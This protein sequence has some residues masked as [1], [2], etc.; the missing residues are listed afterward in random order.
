MARSGAR[1]RW[2]DIYQRLSGKS[3][4]FWR[5]AWKGQEGWRLANT[6]LARMLG[7]PVDTTINWK[8]RGISLTA[9]NLQKVEVVLAKLKL[10]KMRIAWMLA[11]NF[12]ARNWAYL[13]AAP[14][15]LEKSTPT[16][17]FFESDHLNHLVH[18][19]HHC[20]SSGRYSMTSLS[21]VS[22]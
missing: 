22:T 14:E 20:F 4:E 18:V 11:D 8:R 3:K 10:S 16:R 6:E 5:K 15:H 12:P 13:K 21:I 1:N 17:I 2:I 7:V 19:L 9:G